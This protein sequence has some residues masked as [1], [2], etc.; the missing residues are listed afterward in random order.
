[1]DA[2]LRPRPRAARGAVD[3][4]EDTDVL[5]DVLRRGS[6]GGASAGGAS[7]ARVPAQAARCMRHVVNFCL[8][9]ESKAFTETER[10]WKR[11]GMKHGARPL[12]AHQL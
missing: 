12:T 5:G 2:V 7:A 9:R 6:G 3:A 10:K 1:L 8:E 11:G 4:E